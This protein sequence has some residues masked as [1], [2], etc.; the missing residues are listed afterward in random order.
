MYVTNGD[1]DKY[2]LILSILNDYCYLFLFVEPVDNK[3]V[4]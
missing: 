4:Q 3:I 1:S 2:K